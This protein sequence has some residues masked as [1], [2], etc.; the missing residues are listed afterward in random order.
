MQF[1]LNRIDAKARENAQRATAAARAQRDT[2]RLKDKIR[3]RCHELTAF[4]AAKITG[5]SES[6]V[7][8]WARQ[9]GEKLRHPINWKS[10]VTD[11]EDSFID[12]SCRIDELWKISS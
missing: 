12:R 2:D 11:A 5:M 10:P 9:M 6:T 3:G 4:Q 1:G 7:T 8:R